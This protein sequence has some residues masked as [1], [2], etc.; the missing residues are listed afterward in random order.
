M[1][2]LSALF[3]LCLALA[4]LGILNGCSKPSINLA[5]AS[6]PNVNPDFTGRPSPVI[7][8]MYELRNDA[9]FHA[10]DFHPLFE[11]P[12][13]TLGADLIAADELVFTPGEARK[14]AYEPAGDTRYIGIVAGF[15]QLERG[16]WRVVKS[17]DALSKN[18]IAMELS[19]TSI[20]LIPDKDAASWEPAQAVRT[21]QQRLPQVP[22]GAQADPA[23]L[24]V[25]TP[26]NQSQTTI[27]S[28]PAPVP[29]MRPIQ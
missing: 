13:Q 12:V 17:V 1:T 19:D 14:I 28:G 5:V 27:Q 15:R 16:S 25:L 21:Y 8:K 20:I 11:T 22:R 26:G 7:V 2:R 24:P 6:Q 23:E 10:A 18:T 29:A 3:C 4:G 9:A